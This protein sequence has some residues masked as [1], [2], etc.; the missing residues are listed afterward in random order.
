[1]KKLLSGSPISWDS[2]KYGCWC[3]EICMQED[4]QFQND[5][6][7]TCIDWPDWIEK[8]SSL[9][10]RRLL[11]SLISHR[12]RL[13]LLQDL[14]SSQVS[15]M[16]TTGPPSTQCSWPNLQPSTYLEQYSVYNSRWPPKSTSS[17][18]NTSITQTT[19]VLSI[20]ISI[21]EASF[22]IACGR[23]NH[24]PASKLMYLSRYYLCSSV[25]LEL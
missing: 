15:K 5:I 10:H 23:L 14:L 21:Q 8:I 25:D 16:P 24:I 11:P 4:G 20:S 3:I 6:C 2:G 19:K 18:D 22:P 9:C 17:D 7:N 12:F 13:I 1:M